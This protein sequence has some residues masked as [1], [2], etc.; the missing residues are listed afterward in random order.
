MHPTATEAAHRAKIAAEDKCCTMAAREMNVGELLDQ[1]IAKAERLVQA[2]RTLKG[3]L[4]TDALNGGA[5]RLNF[6]EL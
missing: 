4:S 5:S 1:R 2:L 6:L 3:A